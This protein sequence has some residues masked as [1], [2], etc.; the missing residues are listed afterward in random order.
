MSKLI[1]H[2]TNST[3]EGAINYQSDKVPTSLTSTGQVY[4]QRD[5][6]GTDAPPVGMDMQERI[7]SIENGRLS[8]EPY[9]LEVHGF[10]LVEHKYDHIDY[11]EEE[12]IVHRYYKEVEEFVKKTSGAKKVVAYDHN[13]RSTRTHNWINPEGDATNQ[14]IKGGNLVQGPALV[15]HNDFSHDSSARRL[16]QLSELPKV[17]DTWGKRTE[18][19]P[20]LTKDDIAQVTT[21]GGRYIFLNLWRNITD[22]PVQDNHLAMCNARSIHPQDLITFEI[23]YVDRIGENYIARYSSEHQWVYFPRLTKDEALLLKVWDSEGFYADLE[24]VQNHPEHQQTKPAT[25]SLHTAFKDTTANPNVPKRVS[26]EVRVV[27]LFY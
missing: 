21:Q 23:R 19:E 4:F 3:V 10:Q 6:T 14:A 15:V 20:L 7:V 1:D 24:D 8:E 25:F 11:F 13:I 5:E 9:S 17:N 16:H 26:M 18:G 22:E 2:A 27:A 12:E